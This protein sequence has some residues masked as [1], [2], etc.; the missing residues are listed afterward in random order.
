MGEQTVL[1]NLQILL[2]LLHLGQWVWMLYQRRLLEKNTR[3]TK[4]ISEDVKT[5]SDNVDSQIG[6]DATP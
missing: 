5:L 6:N 1:V 3:I 2:T 4:K